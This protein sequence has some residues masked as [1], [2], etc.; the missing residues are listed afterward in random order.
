MATATHTPPQTNPIDHVMQLSSGCLMASCMQVVLKLEIADRIG[1]GERS[2]AELAQATGVKE[3]LLY[4]VMRFLASAGVFEETTSRRFRNT[5]NS[6][7]MQ[8]NHPHSTYAMALWIS[9]P[10][11]FKTYADLM[12]TMRDGKTAIEHVFHMPPFDAIFADKEL[13]EIFNNA[14]TN[15][16][17]SVIP[18]VLEVY[19]FD[20]INTL[21]D[22]AGGHGFVLTSILEKNPTMRGIL[23]DLDHV[24]A[25]AKDRIKQ[26]KLE[27]RLQTASGD[28]FKSVPKADGYVMKHII[29]DWD[30][31]EAITILKNC[32]QHLPSGG[33]VI[34]IEAVVAPGN[35]PHFAKMVDIEMFAMPG[36]RERTEE[37][38]RSLFQRAGLK[39]NRIV[40]TKSPLAVVEAVKV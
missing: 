13:G 38:F 23:F 25:G 1:E 35:E 22:I 31:P 34:L 32:A 16:S 33:K 17:A 24:V 40:P 15:M 7:V 30:D 4:R 6:E 20:G 3:D 2:S 27:D 10:F 5:P 21:A 28:F 8:K 9:T 36:G 39:L 12:P 29:H 18:A 14:M 11:H 26:K 19:D 37:E